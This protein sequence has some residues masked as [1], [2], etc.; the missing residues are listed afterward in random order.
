MNWTPFSVIKM[1][2]KNVHQTHI[3]QGLC[4][5]HQK[6]L[7][8][9]ST[10]GNPCLGKRWVSYCFVSGLTC[11]F[12]FFLAT[13][14]TTVWHFHVV[15]CYQGLWWCSASPLQA[16][17]LS[18][19]WNKTENFEAS[20]IYIFCHI[21]W[22]T[23]QELQMLTQNPFILLW[24]FKVEI[25]VLILGSSWRQTSKIRTSATT[26]EERPHDTWQWYN[27]RHQNVSYQA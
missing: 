23:S 9:G 8:L 18:H 10:L 19:S 21:H 4:L 11:I 24:F 3:A 1:L 5:P 27:K 7:H 15:F 14:T 22:E 12:M 25:E 17:I 20:L 13:K 2:I 26:N 6:I 16:R